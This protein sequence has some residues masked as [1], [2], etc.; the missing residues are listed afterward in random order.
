MST[1][2]TLRSNVYRDYEHPKITV[3]ST[4]DAI[5]FA[6]SRQQVGLLFEELRISTIELIIFFVRV[7]LFKYK[8]MLSIV[9]HYTLL[10]V[11]KQYVKYRPVEIDFQP[12]KDLRLMWRFAFTAIAETRWR[13]YRWQ[14]IDA[15][16]RAY[17]LY[18]DKYSR[19][20]EAESRDKTVNDTDARIIAQLEKDLTLESILDVRAA[21]KQKYVKP[22]PTVVQQQQQQQQKE[23]LKRKQSSDRPVDFVE[24]RLLVSFPLVSLKL[25]HSGADILH[26]SLSEIKARFD[27]KPVANSLYFLLKTRG[28]DIK[29]AYYDDGATLKHSAGQMVTVVQSKKQT[30]TTA[31]TAVRTTPTPSLLNEEDGAGDDLFTF[32][33]ETNPSEALVGAHAEFS[34]R[35]RLASLDVFYER[36]C[37]LEVLRFFRTDLIDFDENVK[38]LRAEVWS[39]AGLIYAV[40]SHKQ[41]HVRAEL[42]SPYFILPASG[43]QRKPS[44]AIVVFLGNTLVQSQ[45][46]PKHAN[47]TPRNVHDL[48]QHFYDKLTLS[49][50][51]V[52]VAL[53][54]AHEPVNWLSVN[55]QGT[56]DYKYHLLY[57]VSTSN[58]LHLSINP[59]YKKLPKLKIDGL[60]SSIHLS[61]SDATIIKLVE[62]IQRFPKPDLPAA[63][64]A[65]SHHSSS[66]VAGNKKKFPRFCGL[67]YNHSY[68]ARSHNKGAQKT[69]F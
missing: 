13:S 59:S 69:L 52:Q 39:R 49:V 42:S 27:V 56:R 61:F 48:Q 47:Y 57:P 62:F 66:N 45:L 3:E 18:M 1:R 26:A 14:R 44:D 23:P 22:T 25:R 53:L 35:A 8:T 2:L 51:D 7:F 9:D 30:T 37:V 41:F 68:M 67:K 29:G 20:L 5:S 31:T 4:T 32:C 6:F 21:L 33:I 58:T 17:K 12:D 36:T 43:T 38:K 11:Y 15:H 28:I 64:A 50:T 54:P 40:E 24:F 34:V 16:W 60:C 65:A 10:N 55:M 63:A 19:K 46:Q